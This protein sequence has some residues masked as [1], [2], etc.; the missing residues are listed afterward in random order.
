VDKP[1]VAG[2]VD[3]GELDLAERVGEGRE[4]QNEGDAPPLLL[5]EA[6]TVHS[7]ER[8]HQRSLSVVDVTGSAEDDRAHPPILAARRVRVVEQ[9]MKIPVAAVTVVR[10]RLVERGGRCLHAS[11]LEDNLVLDDERR[12]LAGTGRLLRVRTMGA[13]CWLTLKGPGSFAGGV[14]SRDEI[15]TSVES[16]YSALAILDGLGFRPVR[17]YQK[18]REAWSLGPIVV[19]L[20]ET[21]AGDFVELEGP[22]DLLAEAA[23]GLGLDPAS[24]VRATYLDLWAAFRRVHPDAPVDM[25]FPL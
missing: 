1:F 22:A 10:G 17:R 6:V 7:R 18:R 23:A 8:S 4:A 3:E 25:V 2:D 5:R 12:T 24:A 19:A 16:A 21:P 20:D 15:E 13:E 11:A 14:K 9:E